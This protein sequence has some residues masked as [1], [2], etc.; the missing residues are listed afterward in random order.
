MIKQNKG[1]NKMLHGP[2]EYAKLSSEALKFINSKSMLQKPVIKKPYEYISPGTN[3][4][5]VVKPADASYE[6]Q[7]FSQSNV[8]SFIHDKS[9]TGFNIDTVI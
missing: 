3:L 6:E 2:Q 5:S 4:K 1:E 8:T 7:F 9:K